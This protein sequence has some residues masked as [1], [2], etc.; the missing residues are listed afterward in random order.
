MAL[1]QRIQYC[2][3]AA[4]LGA[5]LVCAG[6]ASVWEDYTVFRSPVDTLEVTSSK[7]APPGSFGGEE[8]VRGTI[9]IVKTGGSVSKIGSHAIRLPSNPMRPITA[10]DYE[11]PDTCGGHRFRVYEAGDVR[12]LEYAYTAASGK[13][14][15][16]RDYVDGPGPFIQ[17]GLWNAYDHTGDS[18]STMSLQYAKRGSRLLK[19]TYSQG[20]VTGLDASTRRVLGAAYDRALRDSQACRR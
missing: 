19:G 5:S 16:I 18:V 8:D 20:P 1:A 17:A 7:W 12:I 14:H 13:S 9:D 15:I 2:A 6:C 10:F 3:A 11:F 4:F